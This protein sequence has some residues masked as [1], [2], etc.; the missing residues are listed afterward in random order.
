MHST[1]MILTDWSDPL[2]GLFD[3][4]RGRPHSIG[5]TIIR[6]RGQ[7]MQEWEPHIH[8]PAV[9]HPPS[10]AIVVND[11]R[12]TTRKKHLRK[13]IKSKFDK[14]ILKKLSEGCDL[15][16]DCMRDILR[17]QRLLE[18]NQKSHYSSWRTVSIT[19]RPRM[20][21]LIPIH[22]HTLHEQDYSQGK[23]LNKLKHWWANHSF[24]YTCHGLLGN[25]GIL[26]YTVVRGNGPFH[27]IPFSHATYRNIILSSV[28]SLRRD[29]ACVSSFLSA[30]ITEKNIV[31]SA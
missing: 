21:C 28:A 1:Q 23:F 30:I 4:W 8:H 16:R 12:S 13:N 19:L 7:L 25:S 10:N 17:W 31:S 9:V 27:Y 5:S 26:K 6:Q 20:I 22:E 3:L 29:N 2:L 15:K 24:I 14:L 11:H 18:E